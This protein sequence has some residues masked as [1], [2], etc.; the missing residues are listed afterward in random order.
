MTQTYVS[1]R[2]ELLELIEK[3]WG[4]PTD[5]VPNAGGKSELSISNGLQELRDVLAREREVSEATA[6][7]AL[8]PLPDDCLGVSNPD[9][10]LYTA[11]QMRAYSLGNGS[12]IAALHS[13]VLFR[14]LE[15][16]RTQKENALEALTA[17]SEIEDKLSGG[18]WDEI[19]EARSIA[20]AALSAVVLPTNPALC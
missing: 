15:L 6:T 14:Q 3:T 5:Q 19:E 11:E 7:H 8:L 2:R 17:I 18:D 13:H 9:S 1:L 16:V 10:R 20:D 12:R 4:V